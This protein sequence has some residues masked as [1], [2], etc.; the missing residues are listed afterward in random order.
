VEAKALHTNT[1]IV[2]TKLYDHILTWFSCPLT[3]VTN[4]GTHF[5]NDAICYLSDH[6]I[7]KHIIF[8]IHYPQGSGQT[9]SINKVSGTLLIKLVNENQND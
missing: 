8:T 7:L 2:T 1:T 5:I 3:I 4:Q 9:K 6:F